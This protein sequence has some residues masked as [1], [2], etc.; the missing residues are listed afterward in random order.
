VTAQ[1]GEIRAC[2]GCHGVNRDD[3]AG[4]PPATNAPIA[5]RDLL[6]WWSEHTDPIFASGFEAP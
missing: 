2:A 3:Q 1:P 5:L 6:L 4:N